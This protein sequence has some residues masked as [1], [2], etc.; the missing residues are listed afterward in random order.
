MSS[1]RGSHSIFRK[2]KDGGM[3]SQEDVVVDDDDD[4]STM[5]SPGKLYAKD[6]SMSPRGR[7]EKL[8]GEGSREVSRSRSRSSSV[9]R[10]FLGREKRR[11]NK[12]DDSV[13]MASSDMV[14]MTSAEIKKTRNKKIKKIKKTTGFDESFGSVGSITMDEDKSQD[15]MST[16]KSG[17]VKKYCFHESFMD[18]SGPLDDDLTKDAGLQKKPKKKNKLKYKSRRVKDASG[19]DSDGDYGALDS[20]GDYGSVDGGL[21]VSSEGMLGSA[22]R[23]VRRK[24]K[25]RKSSTDNSLGD[26]KGSLADCSDFKTTPPS[27][28]RGVQKENIEA[29]SEPP[30]SPDGVV[31]QNEMDNL[32]LSPKSASG[33]KKKLKVRR[34]LKPDAAADSVVSEK[35]KENTK[36]KPFEPFV[37]H[38]P[39]AR[40]SHFRNG[41]FPTDRGEKEEKETLNLQRQLTEALAKIASLNEDLRHQEGMT[42]KANLQLLELTAELGTVTDRNTELAK[43]VDSMKDDMITKEERIERLQQ[44]VESQLDTVEFLEEKLE[45]TEEEL[46]K[47]EDEM[48]AL[49]DE[50]LLGLD[51]SVHTRNRLKQR[52]SIQRDMLT[53]KGSIRFKTEESR[54]ILESDSL[55]NTRNNHVKKELPSCTIEKDLINRESELVARERKLDEWEQELMKVEVQLKETGDTAVEAAMEAKLQLIGKRELRMVERQDASKKEKEHLLEKI[56]NLENEIRNLSFPPIPGDSDSKSLQNFIEELE[57]EKAALAKENA[58]LKETKAKNESSSGQ[59]EIIR[60]MQEEIAE[61]ESKINNLEEKIKKMNETDATN[62][63]EATDLLIRELQNQLVAAKKEAHELSSG[64][65][66]NKLKAEIKTF[67]KGY[68]DLKKRMKRAADEAQAKLKKKDDSIQFMHKEMLDLKRELERREKRENNLGIDGELGDGDLQKHIEDLEDEVDHWK[69]TNADLENELNLLKEEVSELK[70]NADAEDSD[71]NASVG[72]IQSFNS[73]AS[74]QELFFVSDSNSIRG[75]S[76]I[77]DAP[78]DGSSTPSQRALRSVSNLWS[79]MRSPEPS[80][81]PNPAIPYGAGTLNVD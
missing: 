54:S 65:Y 23:K 19:V 14:S 55:E 64:D 67:Q 47:M 26:S 27:K 33:N 45:Q 43:M 44:V 77:P 49:E 17:K 31:I 38:S 21:S 81:Q 78:Y 73:Y 30:M 60:M 16:K 20:D 6:R 18:S 32:I 56:C 13:S 57:R 71:D 51:Q 3:K 11:T 5:V 28:V 48:K 46:F 34:K 42:S 70:R 72:S 62:G 12:S 15:T 25:P 24:K 39:A 80:H 50:G 2:H 35:P 58:E 76:T 29:I 22:G 7:S 59:D 52:D 66:V 74:Q 41:S 61:K 53:R 9:L 40:P 75:R 8:N 36:S 79:K 4:L 37:D 1:R 63:D 68:N 69:A 10:K